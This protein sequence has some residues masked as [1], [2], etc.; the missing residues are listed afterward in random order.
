MSRTI[1]RL[2]ALLAASDV[3]LGVG[4]GPALALAGYQRLIKEASPWAYWQL[5]DPGGATVAADSSGNGRAGT[6]ASCVSLGE[7][8]PIRD[9]P[10][11]AALL[12]SELGCYMTY[13]S[14]SAYSGSYSVEGWAMPS[15]TT[16]SYQTI[17]DTRAVDGEFSMDVGLG[18]TPAPEGQGFGVDIGDGS[19]WLTNPFIP[20]LFKAHKWFYFAVTVNAATRVATIYING[21]SV[22]RIMLPNYGLPPLLTDGNHPIVLGGNPRYDYP[23]NPAP[24]NF[25]GLIGQVAVY[26]YALSPG[27]VA[28]HY[29][30]G[31][32]PAAA[33]TASPI[34]TGITFNGSVSSPTITVTGTGFGKTPPEGT[35]DAN[36]GCGDHR[37]G[38]GDV[39]GTNGLWFLDDTKVWQAGYSNSSGGNCIGLIIESWTTTQVMF[40]FGVAYDSFDH[41]YAAFGDHYVIDLKGW[42]EGGL[43]S[44]PQARSHRALARHR[45]QQPA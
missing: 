13:S 25:D 24:G 11:T 5:A 41:W 32:Q 30:A 34:I 43:V 33:P 29:A 12:G 20:W 18:G 17:F 1:R 7:P 44:Y 16:K 28:A 4:A 2:I 26:E 40:G 19:E 14:S 39:Y 27:Q 38:N 10:A 37:R 9:N 21:G 3:T 6:Y 35:S 42:Y 31:G 8:G 15:S 22:D 23:S 45:R 36:T